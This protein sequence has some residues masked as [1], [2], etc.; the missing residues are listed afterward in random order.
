MCKKNFHNH[1]LETCHDIF[2]NSLAKRVSD[3]MRMSIYRKIMWTP[4]LGLK[5]KTI[6]SFNNRK[7]C[8]NVFLF[9]EIWKKK[10][11]TAILKLNLFF[12]FFQMPTMPRSQ[13]RQQW[14][15]ISMAMVSRPFHCGSVSYR[16]VRSYW[17]V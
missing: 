11:K 2:A 12:K 13:F 14:S 17:K 7:H 10:Y 3:K 9:L 4:D 16:S 5:I 6:I 15:M 1:L 8:C